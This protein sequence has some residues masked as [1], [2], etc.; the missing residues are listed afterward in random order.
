VLGAVVMP[1]NLFL[2]SEII[3]SRH[4]NLEKEEVIRKQLKFEFLDTLLGMG[5]GWAINSAMILVAASVFFSHGILVDEL[6]Q[7]QATLRPL[8]GSM[9]A[10]VFAL[11]LCFAGFSSSITA[12]MAGGSILAGIFQRPFDASQ[13]LS[14]IGILLTLC[15]ALPIIFLIKDSLRSLIWSQVALSI[16]LPFTVF[17]LLFLTSSTRVMGQFVNSLLD[18]FPQASEGLKEGWMDFR[19]DGMHSLR[20]GT[21]SP[22][23][24]SF[25]CGAWPK[26]AREAPPCLPRPN[27]VGGELHVTQRLKVD[28]SQNGISLARAADESYIEWVGKVR[29]PMNS[30]TDR[31]CDDARTNPKDISE[32]G[33][34]FEEGSREDGDRREGVGQRENRW[35]IGF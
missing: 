26:R 22:G 4:W 29:R 21:P 24:R 13:R 11:A 6:H 10:T 28:F 25:G 17:P 2:H 34:R 30:E 7:A 35:D 16:Q 23:S 19:S 18:K 32:G 1:H 5:I 33:D 20:L 14:R 31:T 3:Q 8:L 27:G 15:C 12:G 9:A